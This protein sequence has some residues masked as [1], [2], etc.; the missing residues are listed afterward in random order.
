MF[1]HLL[2]PLT[3][4]DLDR[5]AIAHARS[6]ALESGGTVEVM[7]VLEAPAGGPQAV[8]AVEWH[9]RRMAAQAYLEQVTAQLAGAGLSVSQGLSEGQ[10]TENIV[11]RAHQGADLLVLPMGASGR[12]HVGAVGGEVLSRSFVSTLLVRGETH[13][14]RDGGAGPYETV[15]VA[16]DG[17]Q[18]A[19]CVLPAVRFLAERFGA[20]VILAHVVEEPSVP[21]PLPPGAEERQLAARLVEL[22]TA[23]ATRYLDDLTTGLGHGAEARL[24][25]GRRAAPGLHELMREREP[26][27]VVMSAHGY[28]GDLTWPFGEVTTN[29]IG[30]GP[31][32][33]LVIH[34]L[35]WQERASR[36]SEATDE[37]WGG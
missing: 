9:A 31:T 17:S 10:A 23:A 7:Y 25:A 20:H 3:G 32:P 1:N 21:R 24:V 19:E 29:L 4:T 22:N 12:T 8:D 26:D 37:A 33:L 14:R 35:P 18:R 5:P 36:P 34:D 6:L 28:D 27:L 15:L 30:Y 13:G 2:L 11:H 16:L